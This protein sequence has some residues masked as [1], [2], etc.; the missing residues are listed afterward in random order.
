MEFKSGIPFNSMDQVIT[1]FIPLTGIIIPQLFN[2]LLISL[3]IS[4]VQ[5]YS[6]IQQL[7]LWQWKVAK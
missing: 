6:L 5:F 4:L 7:L 1:R 2:Y 3:L